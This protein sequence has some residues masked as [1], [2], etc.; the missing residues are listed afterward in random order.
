MRARARLGPQKPPPLPKLGMH[1]VGSS[2]A[3]FFALMSSISAALAARAQP[4]APA[5]VPISSG[6]LAELGSGNP[7]ADSSA[8]ASNPSPATPALWEAPAVGGAAGAAAAEPAA[9]A[10]DAE[11]PKGM[12]A[13][14]CAALLAAVA[15]VQVQMVLAQLSKKTVCW[16]AAGARYGPE[17][18][19]VVVWVTR[20]AVTS[21][22]QVEHRAPI[23]QTP[24]N[25][26][27]VVLDLAIS[28]RS[29]A[30]CG[31]LGVPDQLRKLVLKEYRSP[32][33]RYSKLRGQF[34]QACQSF[35]KAEQ[36][37]REGVGGKRQGGQGVKSREGKL[38]AAATA[39]QGR[40]EDLLGQMRGAW[41]EAKKR[42]LLKAP[43]P[44]MPPSTLP[45]FGKWE[46]TGGHQEELLHGVVFAGTPRGW[47]VYDL[48]ATAVSRSCTQKLRDRGVSVRM[49]T[50]PDSC[51]RHNCMY[52]AVKIILWHMS[53]PV[54]VWD[55]P[56]A[57][58][59]FAM[60][61]RQ[62]RELL[63]NTL[64]WA[65]VK[66]SWKCR[67]TGWG[68]AALKEMKE[69][70]GQL[71]PVGG[72]KGPVPFAPLSGNMVPIVV[73]F[74]IANPDSGPAIPGV[75]KGKGKGK[76]KRKG[77]GGF[78]LFRLCPRDCSG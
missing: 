17:G 67:R 46:V 27:K 29:V 72:G 37:V 3:L 13:A 8:G 19:G 52:V 60:W 44:K 73:L 78:R 47:E 24:P 12:R 36:A 77:G 48:A 58:S 68:P 71:A 20:G 66:G 22:R 55:T 42:R 16:F 54:G 5:A 21:R 1:C 53:H 34:E 76:G 40:A 64:A 56:P 35:K 2:S 43:L 26:A 57:L 70:S 25:V 38:R 45:P 74:C 4:S 41:E 32:A 11:D 49:H 51:N 63:D 50:A 30:V 39:Q 62:C 18:E 61:G 75:G 59:H 33:D 23:G 10:E 6:R 31:E 9:A 65:Q 14:H 7:S 15:A 69:V 28:D